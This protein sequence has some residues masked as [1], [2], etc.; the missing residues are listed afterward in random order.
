[1]NW[2]KFKNHFHVSWHRKMQKFIESKECDDIYTF[3]KN[4]KRKI[5]PSSHLTYRCFK[6][7]PLNEVKVVLVGMCP[8]HTIL[9]GQQVADGLLM[10]CS[11]T[12]KIQPTLEHFYN[13]LEKEYYDGFNLNYRK[14]PDVSYLTRQGVLMLNSALTTV[15][16]KAGAHQELWIPFMKFLFTNI[17]NPLNI[18]VVFLGNE[19]Q[20]CLQFRNNN[21][22]NFPLKHPAGAAYNKGEWDTLQSFSRIDEIIFNTNG[23]SIQW[24]DMDGPF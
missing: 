9:N 17:I 3:L 1:M 10:G 6:E 20:K 24:L 18:P 23:H 13:G 15:E 14:N 11:L 22:H 2:E 8:Y 12:E 4:E 19:A 21:D 16:Y 7:T 5:T